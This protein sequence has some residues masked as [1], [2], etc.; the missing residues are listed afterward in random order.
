M[1]STVKAASCFLPTGL[2]PRYHHTSKNT[3]N[4]SHQVD[5]VARKGC[6][7]W[8]STGGKQEGDVQ[9]GEPAPGGCPW[10][11]F[12]PGQ[13][14]RRRPG[15][16]PPPGD[17]QRLDEHDCRRAA[18]RTS[19]TDEGRAGEEM[20]QAEGSSVRASWTRQSSLPQQPARRSPAPPASPPGRGKRPLK[21]PHRE[22]VPAGAVFPPA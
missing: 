16:S 14:S 5:Q 22:I 18:A 10:A 8:S 4:S 7:S 21:P 2:P 1:P 19:A 15:S 3:A 12:F 11:F 20:L 17:E 13:G 6:I 9:K